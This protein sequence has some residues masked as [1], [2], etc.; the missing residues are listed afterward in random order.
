VRASSKA[1]SSDGKRWA[2]SLSETYIPHIFGCVIQ[3]GR[4][5]PG[6]CLQD[7]RCNA[8]ERVCVSARTA[9]RA[10]S[11]SAARYQNSKLNCTRAQYQWDT[12]T[13]AY[14]GDVHDAKEAEKRYRAA[15]AAATW[16]GAHGC[17]DTRTDTR[18]KFT[19]TARA[20]QALS[21]YATCFG[22][23]SLS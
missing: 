6:V 12:Y 19:C 1:I 18:G 2:Q 15:D 17:K 9:C 11:Q 16:L 14:A 23:L 22:R 20:R 21:V 5:E 3:P 8:R 7:G 13:E 10:S 4:R